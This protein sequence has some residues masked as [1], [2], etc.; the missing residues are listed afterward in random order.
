MILES[1]IINELT[2]ALI[3]SLN[4]EYKTV[5]IENDKMLRV[6]Q[7]PLEIIEHTLLLQWT[8][9]EGRRRVVTHHTL[10]QRR[11][12]LPIDIKKRVVAFPTHTERDSN[13]KWIFYKHI[14]K[15]FCSPDKK[16]TIIVFKNDQHVKVDITP[17]NV[18]KQCDRAMTCIA[19]TALAAINDIYALRT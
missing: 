19:Y 18:R 3:P 10:F 6:N 9:Y 8:T 7:T 1:Y 17:E 4:S 16:G 2:L 5:V 14:S 12:P 15:Y 11:V 13:C